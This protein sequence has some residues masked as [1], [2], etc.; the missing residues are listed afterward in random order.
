MQFID[1]YILRQIKTNYDISKELRAKCSDKKGLC[2][3]KEVPITHKA[4]QPKPG[5]VFF[6]AHTVPEKVAEE[7]QKDIISSFNLK[8]KDVNAVM[9]VTGN[10]E[11]FV[12]PNEIPFGRPS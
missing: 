10:N 8:A 6:K 3:L 12:L 9:A 2:F 1:L 11:F 4:W 7:L 5:N